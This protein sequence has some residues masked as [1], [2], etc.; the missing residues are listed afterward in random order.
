MATIKQQLLRRI[1]TAKAVLENAAGTTRHVA[2]SLVQKNAILELMEEAIASGQFQS[3]DIADLTDRVLTVPFAEGNVEDILGLLSSKSVAKRRKQQDYTAVTSYFCDERWNRYLD[4]HRDL[5]NKADLLI[6][7]AIEMG[8]INPTEP[9]YKR[10]TSDTL[11]AHFDK[12]TCQALTSASKY[13]L[14]DYIKTSFKRCVRNNKRPPAVYLTK[15]PQDPGQLHR[16]HTAMYE[17]LFK[18]GSEPVRCKLDE[19]LVMQIDN[20]YQCRG[21]M[22][23]SSCTSQT[24]VPDASAGVQARDQ[25]SNLLPV[26]MQGFAQ[27]LRDPR[28]SFGPTINL[29]TGGRRSFRALEEDDLSAFRAGMPPMSRYPALRSDAEDA[30]RNPLRREPPA[31]AASVLEE[32]EEG[33]KGEEAE[34]PASGRERPVGSSQRQPV[35]TPSEGQAGEDGSYIE[36]R[37]SRGNIVLDAILARDLE[38]KKVAAAKAALKKQAQK[39]AKLAEAIAAEETQR[40]P[41]V[42]KAAKGAPAVAPP[43]SF[44]QPGKVT[45]KRPSLPVD[46]GDAKRARKPSLSHEKSRS[47][48]LGRSGFTGPNPGNKKFKYEGDGDD[49]YESEAAAR[50]A[51]EAWLARQ[52]AVAKRA[53]AC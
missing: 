4:P 43:A 7:T 40:A 33:E 49:V 39:D 41:P 34:S 51:A 9:T 6:Q 1:G 5:N 24:C 46:G 53:A 42:K 16:D 47:Q 10:W 13:A 21:G 38:T 25:L 3:E 50:K 28:D 48:F 44:E 20:S 45:C 30:D 27:M 18:A 26:L 12:Q 15:L 52:K 14:M 2:L 29:R 23:K 19:T 37:Q 35:D 31:R 22:R 36:Q 8:C 17:K 11:C 32:E